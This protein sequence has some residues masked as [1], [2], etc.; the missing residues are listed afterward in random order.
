VQDAPPVGGLDCARDL[1]RDAHGLVN[2]ERPLE[3]RA[4]DVLQD[5]VA[6]ADV[7]D[8]ADVWMVQCGDRPRL[9]LE[10]APSPGIRGPRF[11]QDP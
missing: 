7:V 5:Q 8:L 6:G 10:A 11:R 1:E 4:C 9:L 3:R 2:P